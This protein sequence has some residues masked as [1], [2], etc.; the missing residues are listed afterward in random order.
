MNIICATEFFDQLG[1]GADEENIYGFFQDN[2]D[3]FR[4]FISGKTEQDFDLETLIPMGV[5][6]DI[7]E[8]KKDILGQMEKLKKSVEEFPEAY[9]EEDGQELSLI[10]I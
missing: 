2:Y 9:R 1:T 5:A 3:K 6:F 10:H 7:D 8:Y 4:D